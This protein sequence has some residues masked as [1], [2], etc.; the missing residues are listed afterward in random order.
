MH[1]IS[2]T[3][4]SI[5][6]WNASHLYAGPGN[7]VTLTTDEWLPP[8]SGW[9]KLNFDGAFS[10]STGHASIGEVARDPFGDLILAYNYQVRAAHPLEAEL[11]ALERGL[12]HLIRFNSRPLMIEGDYLLLITNIMNF[13]HLSWSMMLLW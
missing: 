9:I 5:F 2:Q 6:Y 10:R 8:P 7:N 3:I 12:Q 1:V 4:N 11:L 13:G